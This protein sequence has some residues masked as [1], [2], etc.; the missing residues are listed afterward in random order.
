MAFFDC[1]SDFVD[2]RRDP[3]G[4]STDRLLLL[5]PN[6]VEVAKREQQTRNYAI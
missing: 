6:F 4:D 3:L 2:G 1:I 5:K